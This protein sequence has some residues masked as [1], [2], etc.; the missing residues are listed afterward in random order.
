MQMGLGHPPLAVCGSGVLTTSFRSITAEPIAMNYAPHPRFGDQPRITGL[1]PSKD[2]PG[3]YLHWHNENSGEYSWSGTSKVISGTAV[4]ANADKQAHALYPL[5]H[6]FDLERVCL[7]CDKPFL[8]FAEEQ[9]YWYEELKFALNADCVRCALCRK[10]MHVLQQVRYRYEELEG[11]EARSESL[12]HELAETRLTL[13]EEGVFSLK[14]ADAVR[15]FF[16]R[17]PGNDQVESMRVRLQSIRE[18]DGYGLRVV[19][20]ARPT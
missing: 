5:S 16:N 1:N 19:R 10:S 20:G 18:E 12:E 4:L 11:L 9:Q 8:F 13:I 6:Y 2:D 3:V 14:Q 15:A 17:F 7:D